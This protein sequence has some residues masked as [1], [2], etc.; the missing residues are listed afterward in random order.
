M[1]IDTAT[2]AKVAKLARIKVDDDA[3]PAMA[4]EFNMIIGFIGQL[5]EVDVEG[6]EPMTTVTPQRLKRQ[7]DE[8]NDGAQQ[9]LVLSNA[10]DA[11]EGFF[12]VPKVVE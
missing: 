12:A 8:I 2:A 10:T 11:R 3:L 7:M 5:N 6:V 1:T 9:S 4:E